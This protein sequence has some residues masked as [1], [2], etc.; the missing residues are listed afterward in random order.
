MVDTRCS[1]RRAGRRGSSTLPL[2]TF[3]DAWTKVRQRFMSSARRVRLPDAQLYSRDG[4]D[5]ITL[6]VIQGYPDR[7]PNGDSGKVQ[8]DLRDH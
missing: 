5:S 1:E 2:V 3:L 4:L 6:D 7:T 8:L